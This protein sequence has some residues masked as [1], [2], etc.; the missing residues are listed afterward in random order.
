MNIVK[1]LAEYRQGRWASATALLN[2]EGSKALMPAPRLVLAMAQYDQG[3]TKLARQTLA[4]AV[5]AF[6]WSAAEADRRDVWIVH[7]LRREAEA[8]ILTNLPAFLD[9]KYQPGDNDERLALL[10]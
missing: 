4:S 2:G 9:G 1:G 10:G 8:K 5:V 3:Q 7:I 6:D